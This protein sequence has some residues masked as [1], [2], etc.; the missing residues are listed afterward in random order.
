PFIEQQSLSSR[1]DRSSGWDSEHNRGPSATAVK[2]FMCPSQPMQTPESWTFSSYVGIAGVGA[3]AASLPMEDKR[4]GVF[5][6]ERRIILKDVKDGTSVTLCIVETTRDN[7]RWAAGG[8]ST[9]RAFD[10]Q[11]QPYLGEG[12]P[13]GTV[14]R[15]PFVSSFQFSRLPALGNAAM[16]D[17][18]VHILNCSIRSQTLEAL[19]TI[20]GSEEISPDF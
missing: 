4:C 17:G 19:A 14:H 16:L 2:I 12:R 11:Q 3:D 5:G 10:P 9:V 6:Y 20:A 13:F 18:S 1:F 15:Q 8:R 7:G